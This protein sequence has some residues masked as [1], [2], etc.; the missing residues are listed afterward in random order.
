L[1]QN[2]RDRD[3]PCSRS[4]RGAHDRFSILVTHACTDVRGPREQPDRVVMMIMRGENTSRRGSS[5]ASGPRDAPVLR[6]WPHQASRRAHIIFDSNLNLTSPF[7]LTLFKAVLPVTDLMSLPPESF[8]FEMMANMR[9]SLLLLM[10]GLLMPA[11][12]APTDL[13]RLQSV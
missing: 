9:F 8:Y 2:V 13:L 10:P 4:R 12:L 11:G 7:E 1:L 3:R 6:S 5:K